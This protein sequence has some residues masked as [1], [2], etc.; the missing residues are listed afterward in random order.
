MSTIKKIGLIA[1]TCLL[2]ATAFMNTGCRV[3]YKFSEGGSV[4]DSI[5]IVK[6]SYIENKAP[7]TNPQLSP[8][9]TDKLRQKIVSQTRLKQTNGTDADWEISGEI[10]DYSFSTSGISQQ[11]ESTNRLTV[12]VHIVLN[13]LKEGTMEEFDISRNFDFSATLSIDQAGNNLRDE[14]IRGLTDD[15]FN[16]IFSDW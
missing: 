13:K 16:R 4:P 1:L 10:R 11:K 9:L 14:M 15:I 7:Y 12:S 3:Q 6:V 2:A 5:K 8:Q